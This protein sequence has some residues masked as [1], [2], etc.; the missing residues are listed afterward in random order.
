MGCV[1]ALSTKL[2]GSQE[3]TKLNDETLVS[4][5]SNSKFEPIDY[6]D[7]PGSLYYQLMSMT[8]SAQKI[9]NPSSCGGG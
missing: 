4:N 3:D 8:T 5:I 2:L 9:E 6:Q 7:G 1:S